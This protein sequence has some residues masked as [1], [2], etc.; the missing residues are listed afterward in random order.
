MAADDGENG[1]GPETEKA[2]SG[3]TVPGKIRTRDERRPDSP[4]RGAVFFSWKRGGR[5]F[6]SP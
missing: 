2:R 4:E 1:G 5:R 6:A 3:H